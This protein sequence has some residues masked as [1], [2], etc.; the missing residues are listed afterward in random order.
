MRET[1]TFEYTSLLIIIIDDESF[2]KNTYEVIL[3]KEAKK[4][5]KDTKEINEELISEIKNPSSI[6]TFM[7]TGADGKQR[8]A[9]VEEINQ[10][11]QI[12]EIIN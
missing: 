1:N 2:K 9:G 12:N 5:E 6:V 10:F 3:K 7:V 11:T 8:R 4:I